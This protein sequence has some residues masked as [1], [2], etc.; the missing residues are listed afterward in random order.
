MWV[1][2]SAGEGVVGQRARGADG[3][4][5]RRR[6]VVE[7]GEGFLVFLMRT[8][9]APHQDSQNAPNTDSGS[10]HVRSRHGPLLRGRQWGCVGA[11]VRRVLRG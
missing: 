3:E 5:E 10:L 9:P 11:P 6:I 2:A 4:E 8:P 1:R 7:L